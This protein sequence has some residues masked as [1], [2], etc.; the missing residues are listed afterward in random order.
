MHCILA[1]H[2]TELQVLL[3]ADGQGEQLEDVLQHVGVQETVK[4]AAVH[5]SVGSEVV[6]FFHPAAAT[7]TDQHQHQHQQ[8]MLHTITPSGNWHTWIVL[9]FPRSGWPWPWPKRPAARTGRTAETSARTETAAENNLPTPTQY[10]RCCR[11][12]SSPFERTT[13]SGWT[14]RNQPR[15]G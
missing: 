6:V 14:E 1:S 9:A 12:P 7:A 4:A 5:L 2:P 10:P 15:M 3:A 13:G 11:A 8:A